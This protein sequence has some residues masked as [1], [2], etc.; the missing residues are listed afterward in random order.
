MIEA[1]GA[2][3]DRRASVAAC[4]VLKLVLTAAQLGHVAYSGK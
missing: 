3:Q 2:L 1:R 4:T